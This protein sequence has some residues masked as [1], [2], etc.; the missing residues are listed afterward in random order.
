MYDWFI[1]QIVKIEEE[2]VKEGLPF[3]PKEVKGQVEVIIQVEE[4]ILVH[5]HLI[6]LL[7][8]VVFLLLKGVGKKLIQKSKF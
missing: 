2:E 3:Y 5:P 6:H 7:Q 4:G 1:D 8:T